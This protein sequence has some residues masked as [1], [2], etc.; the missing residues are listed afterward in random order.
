MAGKP[1]VKCV[2]CGKD[3]YARP[4]FHN[5]GKGIYCSRDCYNTVCKLIYYPVMRNCLF[6]G[7]TFE[8]IESRY[9]NKKYCS[10]SCASKVNN[11]RRNGMKY[12]NKIGIKCYLVSKFGHFCMFEG[13]DYNKSV[14]AHHV[15]HASKGGDNSYDNCVLLCPNH[16]REVHLNLIS[17]DVLKSIVENNKLKIES[18]E[19][20]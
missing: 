12:K 3:F 17:I 9:R 19:N 10:S 11:K 6:C 8:I 4:S 20:N 5:T 7:K 1:N 2:V 15:V 16:H 13:C 14:D 18:M